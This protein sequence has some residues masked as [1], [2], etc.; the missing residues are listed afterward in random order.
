MLIHRA[1]KQRRAISV[2]KTALLGLGMSGRSV[3]V[4]VESGECGYGDNHAAAAVFVSAPS[5][6]NIEPYYET[7]KTIAEAVKNLIGSLK[8]RA[9]GAKTGTP[10]IAPF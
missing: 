3:C 2:V 9:D 6:S 10:E 1:E 8:G 5:G 7:G 4:S